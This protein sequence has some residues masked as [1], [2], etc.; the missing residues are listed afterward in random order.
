VYK[1]NVYQKICKR[2]KIF[3][4]KFKVSKIIY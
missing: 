2:S 4:R 1:I 3:G